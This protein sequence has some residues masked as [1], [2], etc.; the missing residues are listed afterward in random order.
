MHNLMKSL[1][2]LTGLL[3]SVGLVSGISDGTQK[4]G[5]LGLDLTSLLEE[6]L[7]LAD[8]LEL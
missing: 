4:L 3:I 1:T 6:V 5:S 7:L 2:T 8:A